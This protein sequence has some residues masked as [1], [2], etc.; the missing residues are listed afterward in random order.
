[1]S[2]RNVERLVG[3]LATDEGYRRRFFADRAE[4]LRELVEQGCELTTVE[5][6][7]LLALDSDALE[8]FARGI[9]PRLQKV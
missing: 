3:K 8:S 4:A 1:M 6:Q 9:D 2:Q 5:M 7:A